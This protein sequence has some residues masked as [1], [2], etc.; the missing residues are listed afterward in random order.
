MW[1]STGAAVA[2]Q[3]YVWFAWRTELHCQLFTR[4]LGNRAFQVYTALFILLLFLRFVLIFLLGYA[5]RGNLPVYPLIRWGVAGLILLPVA[6]TGYSIKRY[7][8]LKRV[9][10]IDHFDPAYR[11]LGLVRKGIFRYTSNAMYLYVALMFWIP[12]LVFASKAALIAAFFNHAY[13][14]VHYF[15]VEKPDISRIYGK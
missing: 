5:N 2:H 7:F 8:P 1:L 13:L 6:W 4:R 9:L 12:A 3:C 14:W 10:G 15:T 11:S